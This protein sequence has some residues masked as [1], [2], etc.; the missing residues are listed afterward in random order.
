VGGWSKK[1]EEMVE[2]V[3]EREKFKR[4][5]RRFGR[6]KSLLKVKNGQKKKKSKE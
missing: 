1:G 4:N 6:V 5:E 2:I 3:K